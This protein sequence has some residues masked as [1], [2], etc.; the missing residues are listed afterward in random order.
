MGLLTVVSDASARCTHNLAG[1]TFLVDLAKTAPLA[2]LLSGWDHDKVHILLVAQSLD[3][4][5]VSGLVAVLGEAAEAGGVHVL[6]Y[7]RKGLQK[8]E[9]TH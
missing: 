8:K 1:S 2:K 3:K 6:N 5:G 9:D 4:A 7:G